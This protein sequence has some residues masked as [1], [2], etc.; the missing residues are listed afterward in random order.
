MSEVAAPHPGYNDGHLDAWHDFAVAGKPMDWRWL[1]KGYRAC[2]D[3]PTCI[4]YRELMAVFPHAR[5]VFTTRDS[6]RW[7]KSWATLWSAVDL[8]ND[9][10]RVIHA[11][12]FFPFVEVLLRNRRFGGSI[13]RESSIA[14]FNAHIE[15]RPAMNLEDLKKAG[16]GI[17]KAVKNYRRGALTKAA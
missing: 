12:K 10:A 6:D 17:E 9:P 5:V 2:V 3:F 11:Q 15:L 8:F 14:A 7:F 16:P 13:E 4:Y 1:F